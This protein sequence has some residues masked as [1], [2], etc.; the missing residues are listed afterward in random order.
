MTIPDLGPLY[1]PEAVRFTFQ[2]PGWY[3]LGAVLLLLAAFSI[4][5]GL[6]NYMKNAYRREA[7]KDLEDAG[8]LQATLVVLKRVAI[9]VFGRE[10]VAALHGKAW[11]E[12]LEEKGKETHF[13]KYSSPIYAALYKGE[14]LKESQLREIVDLSKKWILT[15]A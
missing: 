11:L 2:S 7:L 8:S 3:I 6:R 15:H 4:Y 12:Y 14:D 5:R 10:N 9:K 1:E 13:L